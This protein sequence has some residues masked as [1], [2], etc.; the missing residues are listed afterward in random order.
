MLKQKNQV[1]NLK[2][3]DLKLQTSNIALLL[4]STSFVQHLPGA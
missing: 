2:D 4:S 1:T 3:I